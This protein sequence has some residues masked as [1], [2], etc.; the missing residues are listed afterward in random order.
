MYRIRFH[1]RDGH[2]VHTRI[3]HP[4]LPVEAY[5]A[6]RARFRRLFESTRNQ[7]LIVEIRAHVDACWAGVEESDEHG[8]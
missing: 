6:T 4:Q 1:G 3:P 2:V 7:A 5:P 8:T